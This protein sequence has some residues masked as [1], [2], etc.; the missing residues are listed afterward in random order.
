MDGHEQV[1]YASAIF[2]QEVES[3]SDR[4]EKICSFIQDRDNFHV[5]VCPFPQDV[6]CLNCKEPLSFDENLKGK[7][8]ILDFFTYCCINCMHVLPGKLIN[9]SSISQSSFSYLK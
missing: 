4:E 6:E 2:V 3:C 9:R 8:V 7:I 1:S 5:P